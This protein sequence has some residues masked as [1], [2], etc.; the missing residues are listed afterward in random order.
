M[1]AEK[2]HADDS[3]FKIPVVELFKNYIYP[4]SARFLK[5]LNAS[6]PTV[7]YYLCYNNKFGSEP[8]YIRVRGTKTLIIE[9]SGNYGYTKL[10]KISRSKLVAFIHL[11]EFSIFELIL[12]SINLMKRSQDFIKPFPELH[13]VF[14]LLNLSLLKKNIIE[15]F[16]LGALEIDIHRQHENYDS[17]LYLTVGIF[18]GFISSVMDNG[19]IKFSIHNIR[20]DSGTDLHYYNIH[21][22]EFICREMKTFI[23]VLKYVELTFNQLPEKVKKTLRNIH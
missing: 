7:H 8:F 3:L 5:L 11:N 17:H 23:D 10:R 6:D 18:Q 21:D 14:S 12:D 22:E 2:I 20:M 1:K 15:D 16:N 9:T 19:V 4:K 13:N